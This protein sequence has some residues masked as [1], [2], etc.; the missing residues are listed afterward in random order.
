MASELLIRQIKLARL[1]GQKRWPFED[2]D[3]DEI[4]TAL[5]A[6]DDLETIYKSFRWAIS[7]FPAE[8]HLDGDFW[9]TSG[10]GHRE[11]QDC[12]S[13]HGNTIPAALRAAA[14]AIQKGENH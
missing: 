10:R 13:G 8:C 2:C 5:Q 4:L 3:I 6:M 14:E 12:T 9:V 7:I 1:S 11:G